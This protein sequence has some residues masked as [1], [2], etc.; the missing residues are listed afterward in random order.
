MQGEDGDLP[1]QDA[2][3][4]RERPSQHASLAQPF[5]SWTNQHRRDVPSS[6]TGLHR[7]RSLCAA[8]FIVPALTFFP[9]YRSSS[10][11]AWTFVCARVV[12]AVVCVFSGAQ[13][14]AAQRRHAVVDD[15]R[16]GRQ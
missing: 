9:S 16:I 13:G 4:V 11:S 14:G 7:P 3:S 15:V 6:T 10:G 12:A 5:Q 1:E 8:A 2:S